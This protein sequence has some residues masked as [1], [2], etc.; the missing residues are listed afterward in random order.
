MIAFKGFFCPLRTPL[1]RGVFATAELILH[2]RLACHSRSAR[3][4]RNISDVNASSRA[5]ASVKWLKHARRRVLPDVAFRPAARDRMT[6]SRSTPGY[7]SIRRV[8][9]R[10]L[11]NIFL[12]CDKAWHSAV[13]LLGQLPSLDH[14]KTGQWFRK[15]ST[16]RDMDVLSQEAS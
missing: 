15:E 16:W 7:F 10:G 3:C 5:N 14:V 4:A 11:E 8:M 12:D 6:T 1:I 9:L 13:R 2:F